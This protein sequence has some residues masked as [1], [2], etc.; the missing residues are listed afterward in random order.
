MASA[1]CTEVVDLSIGAF[2]KAVTD[3]ENYPKFVS[4]MKSVSVE[5]EGQNK[6]VKFDLEMMKR[7]EYSVDMRESFDEAAGHAEISWTLKDSGLFKVNNGKWSLK[8]LGPKKTQVTYSLDVEF[9]F[10]VPGFILNKLVKK[11]LPANIKSF[12]SWAS[13]KEKGDK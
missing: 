12:A 8:A 10:G 3:Y 2:F 4:G 1:E 6:V 11:N 5:G 13:L 9:S 7:F